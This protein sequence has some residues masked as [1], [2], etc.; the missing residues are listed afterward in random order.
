VSI[1]SEAD[2]LGMRAVGR[3]VAE[4]LREL[5]LALRPGVT[6]AEL[7]AVGAAAL[8]RRG[9]RPAPAAL[10]GFPASVCISVDDEAV[11]GIPGRGRIAPG[12][13]VKLDVTAQLD[14][15]V[16]DAAVT[17]VVP[18]ATP[19]AGRLAACASA[20]L[21]RALDQARAGR[22]VAAIGRAVEREVG[23][24]GFRVLAELC[25]HGTGRAIWE[26]PTVPNVF[27]PSGERLRE[28]LVLA[29]EPIIAAADDRVVG[30]GDG[31]T[32]RTRGG[33]LAAHVEHTIVIRRGRPLVLTAA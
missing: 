16:A 26:R 32:L 28:G 30:T 8:R 27:V 11:H 18:P 17:V 13:V 33:S 20:A 25:G 7:D 1:E 31:W 15:Y 9:A 5:R 4:C 22:P 21:D 12:D 2:L 19:L 6:T 23:R 29:V 3:A 10:L 24:R 14:G